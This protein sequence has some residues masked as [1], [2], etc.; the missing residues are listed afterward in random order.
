MNDFV[1]KKNYERLKKFHRV[2]SLKEILNI[3]FSSRVFEDE[4]IIKIKENINN[5]KKREQI[6]LNKIDI[7]TKLLEKIDL[8]IH[9]KKILN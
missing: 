3:E 1:F 4:T 5:Y 6:R 9:Q 2:K 8:K 7:L